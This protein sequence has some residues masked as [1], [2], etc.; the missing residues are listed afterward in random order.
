MCTQASTALAAAR[1]GEVVADLQTLYRD[2][3]RVHGPLTQPWVPFLLMIKEACDS[4]R[5]QDPERIPTHEALLRRDD[6]RC[7]FPGCSRRRMLEENHIEPKARGGSNCAEN[8]TTLCFIHH[9]QVFH[10]GYARISGKAPHA[11]RYEIGISPG[12]PPLLVTLGNLIIERRGRPVGE[13][14]S[15]CVPITAAA[16]GSRRP[17]SCLSKM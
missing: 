9:R 17:Q 13:R 1:S 15:R 6:Y 7:T 16:S 12:R 5:L 8:L 4:W 2:F 11:L 3:D 14:A 10:T